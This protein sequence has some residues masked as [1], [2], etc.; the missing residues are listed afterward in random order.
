MYDIFGFT[1][2]D[3]ADR[4]RWWAV[5]WRSSKETV[6]GTLRKFVWSRSHNTSRTWWW[7]CVDGKWLLQGRPECSSDE[8]TVWDRELSH[9]GLVHTR[10][11]E[12]GATPWWVHNLV[13]RGLEQKTSCQDCAEWWSSSGVPAWESEKLRFKSLPHRGFVTC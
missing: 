6:W 2:R 13:L 11:S 8:P 3:K 9:C 4:E 5:R 7:P 1:L 10:D 12:S